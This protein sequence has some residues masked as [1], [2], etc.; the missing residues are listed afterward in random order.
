MSPHGS[1]I[2]GTWLAK[3][4]GAGFCGIPTKVCLMITTKHI[5][6]MSTR[7]LCVTKDILLIQVKPLPVP[8]KLLTLHWQQPTW[9]D[10]ARRTL[11]LQFMESSAFSD[12]LTTFSDFHD[13]FKASLSSHFSARTLLLTSQTYCSGFLAGCS[14]GEIPRFWE[15]QVGDWDRMKSVARAWDQAVARSII[16]HPKA[17]VSSSAFRYLSLHWENRACHR[18]HSLL[19]A[20]DVVLIR[21][22]VPTNSFRAASGSQSVHLLGCMKVP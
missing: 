12:F 15:R 9:L 13:S 10:W 16:K 11:Q 7:C 1:F 20:A 3:V 2:L 18:C 14:S 19:F 6:Q 5:K 17:E 8:R 4:E 22:P 21:L